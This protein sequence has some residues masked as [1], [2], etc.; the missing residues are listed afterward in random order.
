MK[1]VLCAIHSHLNVLL[2]PIVVLLSLSVHCRLVLGVIN[3]PA[4]LV[5]SED[6]AQRSGIGPFSYDGSDAVVQLI[7]LWNGV[8]GIV[9]AASCS[10]RS[11][12]LSL[13]SLVVVVFSLFPPPPA[14]CLVCCL[15]SLLC[16]VGVV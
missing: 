4:S 12:R 10:C 3:G 7:A 13:L 15:V 2:V 5:R 1:S 16:C 6:A 11:I 14:T 8:A 9:S